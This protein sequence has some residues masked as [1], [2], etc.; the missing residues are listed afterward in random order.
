MRFILGTV[1]ANKKL[2][3]TPA[4]ITCNILSI[5]NFFQ[6]LQRLKKKNKKKN[7]KK[8]K[9]KGVH[10]STENKG[11]N[12][13]LISGLYFSQKYYNSSQVSVKP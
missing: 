4:V 13:S 7:K 3:P 9:E 2:S 12:N 8:Q 1:I 10:P 5:G 11:E 6:S